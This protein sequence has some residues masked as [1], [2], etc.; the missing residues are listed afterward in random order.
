MHF[1]VLFHHFFGLLLLVL[2]SSSWLHPVALG[3]PP[4]ATGWPRWPWVWISTSSDSIFYI[5]TPIFLLL[6]LLLSWRRSHVIHSGLYLPSAETVV[7]DH[8][9]SF[10]AVCAGTWCQANPLPTKLHPP[11]WPHIDSYCIKNYLFAH[12]SPWCTCEHLKKV[13]NSLPALELIRKQGSS[14][15]SCDEW[16]FWTSLHW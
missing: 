11:P 8:H 6:L 13:E 9:A 1:P 4:R 5:T 14:E 10:Y 2:L 7:M 15:R 3:H 16:V 12:L